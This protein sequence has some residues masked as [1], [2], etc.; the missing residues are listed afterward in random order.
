MSNRSMRIASA[1]LV[2]VLVL[3]STAFAADDGGMPFLWSKRG[4]SGQVYTWQTGHC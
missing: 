1:V 4:A 2:C 3:A